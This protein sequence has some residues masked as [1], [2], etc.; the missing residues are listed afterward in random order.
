MWVLL[1]FNENNPLPTLFRVQP[2]VMYIPFIRFAEWV[3]RIILRHS[4]AFECVELGQ[5]D[6][7]FK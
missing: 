6:K 3:V 4:C 7:A 2:T 5:L 1:A